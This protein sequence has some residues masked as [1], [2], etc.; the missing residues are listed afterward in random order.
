MY[1]IHIV[2]SVWVAEIHWFVHTSGMQS[3]TFWMSWTASSRHFSEVSLRHR[4]TSPR[5]VSS[6]A[7]WKKTKIACQVIKK[8]CTPCIKVGEKMASRLGCCPSEAPKPETFKHPVSSK[9]SFFW[10]PY[11]HAWSLKNNQLV[12]DSGTLSY[13]KHIKWWYWSHTIIFKQTHKYS[14]QCFSSCFQ[15][16]IWQT[17]QC[18][19]HRLQHPKNHQNDTHLQFNVF[20]T[21]GLS[22]SWF[23]PTT[24]TWDSSKMS[25]HFQHMRKFVLPGTNPPFKLVN[26]LWY[27]PNMQQNHLNNVD[28][29]H[30]QQN[31]K[32]LIFWQ[33]IQMVL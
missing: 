29:W 23:S 30:K 13:L 9:S 18:S 21:V 33:S 2:V 4:S 17:I 27:H 14:L 31:E 26:I 5:I 11:F 8:P 15:V 1:E 7:A 3:A 32:F 22:L 6:H 12:L 24:Q 10:S 25:S 19:L 20:E 28:C 16:R